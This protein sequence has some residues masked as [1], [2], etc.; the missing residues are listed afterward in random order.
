[1]QIITGMHRSGTSFVAS[2]LCALGIPLGNDRELVPTDYW[3][4]AGYYE[5]LELILL[6]DRIIFGD[7]FGIRQFRQTPSGERPFW[8]VAWL[9]LLKVRYIFVRST[10]AINKRGD[11]LQNE[12]KKFAQQNQNLLLKDPR[13]SL[14]LHG[15]RKHGGVTHV[16]Y[17]F[18]HP[19]EV[20]QSLKKREKIPLWLG[21][22]I[23]SF[24]IESF[25]QQTKN[26]PVTYVNFNN[27]FD[28]TLCANELR[29]C[30]A[31]AN[32]IYSDQKAFDIIQ[33]CLRNDLKRHH[34]VESKRLPVRCRKLYDLLLKL[35]SGEA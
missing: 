34:N 10:K 17:S 33:R 7:R 30:F 6:N 18:R 11:S 2:I 35:H 31:F 9:T 19:W 32:Q 5:N 20:A 14:T 15:W 27:F 21:L 13:F 1:M 28:A 29:R 3:N 23:W 22:Q 12:I 4:A 24:H 8:L 26:M 25:L 16:L